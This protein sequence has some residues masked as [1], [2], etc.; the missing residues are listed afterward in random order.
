M[1]T[2]KFIPREQHLREVQ[3]HYF[4][5]MKSEIKPQCLFIDI[6]RERVSSNRTFKEWFR[7]FSNDY[8]E[9]NEKL[10]EYAQK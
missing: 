4:I 5:L 10:C 8:F 1:K 2:L 7:V 3:L 9:V 6:N